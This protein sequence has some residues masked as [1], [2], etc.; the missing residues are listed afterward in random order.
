MSSGIITY[1]DNNIMQIDGQFTGMGMIM[2]GSIQTRNK[3]WVTDG[4]MITGYPFFGAV[5]PPINRWIYGSIGNDEIWGDYSGDGVMFYYTDE[6]KDGYDTTTSP[7]TYEYR[8]YSPV[9][10]HQTN[11]D[12][13]NGLNVWNQSGKLVFTSNRSYFNLEHLLI[14]PSE[15]MGG[16]GELGPYP[17]AY[18]FYYNNPPFGKRFILIQNTGSNWAARFV[19]SYNRVEISSK[20]RPEGYAGLPGITP[21]IIGV[22]F[23]L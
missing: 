22:G 18:N 11:L 9:A 19:D 16:Q 15:H 5:R 2:S 4:S 20:D 8:V 21:I 10:E 13:G 1:N 14:L 6:M 12:F 7:F 23:S 3:V 17:A